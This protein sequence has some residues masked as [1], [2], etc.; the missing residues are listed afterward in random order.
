MT[1]RGRN[2]CSEKKRRQKT[3][4][5]LWPPLQERM[6]T[7]E[8]SRGREFDPHTP[9][10]I[11][12]QFPPKGAPFLQPRRSSARSS[13]YYPHPGWLIH[14]V[15]SSVYIVNT[16]TTAVQPAR[17]I[18]RKACAAH[19][20]TTISPRLR[21]HQPVARTSHTPLIPLSTMAPMAAAF[22]I[23]AARA[24]AAR[25]AMPGPAPGWA[26]RAL[27]AQQQQG[28]QLAPVVRR[29]ATLLPKGR[30]RHELDWNP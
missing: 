18:S 28:Q 11:A 12:P 17:I 13:I 6:H 16:P 14:R 26:A 29:G 25:S 1:E 15:Y 30:S 7:L 21:L 23:T 9:H 4:A 27:A 8:P 20:D 22:M 10:L 3:E 24:A 19:T 5:R 2:A